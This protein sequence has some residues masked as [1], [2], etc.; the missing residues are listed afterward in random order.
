MPR[1]KTHRRNTYRRRTR[2]VHGQGLFSWLGKAASWA[3]NNILPVAKKALK[4]YQ[5][6][7]VRGLVN[8]YGPDKAKKLIQKGDNLLGMA[9]LMKGNGRRRRTVRLRRKKRSHRGGSLGGSLARYGRG[10]GNY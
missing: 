9:G 6:P 5:D 2:R 3:K 7:N 8:Q 1:R 10:L 4:V